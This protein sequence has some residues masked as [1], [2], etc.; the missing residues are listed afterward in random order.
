MLFG[1]CELRSEVVVVSVF[2]FWYMLVDELEMGLGLIG[3]NGKD[4]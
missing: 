2:S 4:G 3:R 1:I